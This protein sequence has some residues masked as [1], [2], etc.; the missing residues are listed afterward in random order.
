MTNLTL[1]VDSREK[2]SKIAVRLSHLGF[3]V[4]TKK[5]FVGDY[6]LPGK[7]IIE[8]KEANDF[9]TSIM[10]GHLFHQA[11]LLASH[12]DRPFIVLE[13]NLDEIYSSIDPESVAGAISALLLFYGIAVAPSPSID[14]T[15][16][17]IGRMIKHSTQGLGYEIP[18]RTSKPKFDGG[19]ALFLVEGL[20]GV[21]PEMARKLI[22]HFG[23]PAKV[24][25]A[26]AAEL[27][28]VKGVGPKTIASIHG[29]LNT[30]PTGFRTTK[31]APT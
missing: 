12:A 25:A 4:R 5:L 20:P 26:G 31:S 8:R 2:R 1:F 6:S 14:A 30:A 16:R 11:E 10:N 22:G 9:V 17:L 3:S 21:G 23:T 15:A 24:F 13:G 19:A 7:F 27:R 28:E 18:L 29:A